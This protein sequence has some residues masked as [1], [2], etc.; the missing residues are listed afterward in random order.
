MMSG[1]CPVAGAEPR[2]PKAIKLA[3]YLLL[4]LVPLFYAGSL[5]AHALAPSLLQLEAAGDGIYAVKWKTPLKRVE[6]SQLRPMLPSHCLALDGGSNKPEGTA[7]VYRWQVDCGEKG[8]VGSA[9]Q[10]SGIAS[11]RAD[12]LLRIKLD[13]GR[14]LNQ[15]LRPDQETF[16]VPERQSWY[17]VFGSYMVMGFE[18]LVGGPDHV[19]FVIALFMLVGLQRSLIWTVT[20]FTL[21]HSVTLSLAVLDKISFSQGMAEIFIA[22]SIIVAFTEVLRHP[23]HDLGRWKVY[24]MAAGFGLLHG[25]GFAGA[26][27]EVGLPQDDIPLALLGFNAGI[28]VGQLA[29]IGVL[30]LLS[31][32]LLRLGFSWRGLW[33]QLPVYAAGSVAGFWFWQRIMLYFI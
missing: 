15:V 6:G 24:L 18:H 13:D 32:A 9:V 30:C 3:L 28:E 20:M 8:L 14:T 2:S 12:A 23:D 26:L 19:L 10:I 22:L 7:M 4:A 11:S 29:L 27:R 31:L 21:G 33:K 1:D 5:R 25:L 17:R 16:L